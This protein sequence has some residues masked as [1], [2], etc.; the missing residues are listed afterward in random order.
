MPVRVHCD[1]DRA[2]PHLL[3]HLRGRSAALNQKRAERVSEIMES[4]TSQTPRSR[5][6]SKWRLYRFSGSSTV[7]AWEG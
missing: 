1:L 5:A 6:G 3:L 4:E 7:P 2:V